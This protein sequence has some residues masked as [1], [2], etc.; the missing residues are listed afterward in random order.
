MKTLALGTLNIWNKSG[1]YQARLPL[2]REELS[3]LQLDVFAAQEVLRFDAQPAGVSL[4]DQAQELADGMNLS[5]SYGGGSDLG[6]GLRLGNALFTPH[7][8]VKS[9]AITLPGAET[10]EKRT[11]LYT[12]VETPFGLLP[13]FVTHLNWKHH[14]G[15]VRLR[16]VLAI[17]DQISERLPMD[18]SWLPPVLMGDLNAEPASDEIRYLSGLHV[19]EG[20]SVFFN[21]VWRYAGEGPGYTFDRRNPFSA[22]SREP[23]RR[24]DY[25]FVGAPDRWLR[26]EPVSAR[27]CFDQPSAGVYA[28]DHF[29]V[30][31]QISA[32][33]RGSG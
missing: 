6:G 10:G 7:P 16:Q 25:I 20:K 27:L 17:C 24:I 12:L 18:E 3:R 23:P 31:A 32:E 19:V 13:T 28:S 9:E 26:G 1:P 11:L 15:A 2:I 22:L 30:Y 14:Q 29:G 5:I 8:I 33:R 21:D 4:A